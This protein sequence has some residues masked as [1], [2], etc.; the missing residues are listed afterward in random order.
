MRLIYNLNDVLVRPM[1]RAKADI[2]TW[3]S[4]DRINRVGR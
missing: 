2:P 4:R 1:N 3:K